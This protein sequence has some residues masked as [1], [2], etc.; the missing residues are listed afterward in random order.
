MSAFAL[1]YAQRGKSM[2]KKFIQ[3]IKIFV[4][5]DNA[6]HIT[7]GVI[8]ASMIVSVVNSLVRDILI[9]TSKLASG[10]TFSESMLNIGSFLTTIISFAIAL[11]SIFLLVYK[12]NKL[13]ESAKS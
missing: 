8:T 13:K 6:V 11:F 7:I 10:Y 12:V 3:G 1:S 5:N 2:L 9:P 4:A